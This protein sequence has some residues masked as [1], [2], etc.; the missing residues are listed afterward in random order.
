MGGRT[1]VRHELSEKGKEMVGVSNPEARE[2]VFN[3]EWGSRAKYNKRRHFN[4]I[5]E[6]INVMGDDFY[7]LDPI[8]L[9]LTRAIKSNELIHSNEVN[10]VIK[11]MCE[12]FT[13]VKTSDHVHEYNQ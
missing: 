1:Y 7:I 2:S 10:N 8:E 13:G 11:D 9:F 6:G 12:P 5:E 3:P 4:T